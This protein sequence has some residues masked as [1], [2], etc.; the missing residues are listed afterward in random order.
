MHDNKFIQ[1]HTNTK[2]KDE[3][4][5]K[6]LWLKAETVKRCSQKWRHQMEDEH[7]VHNEHNVPNGNY[8]FIVKKDTNFSDVKTPKIV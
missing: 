8:F 3:E 6:K 4:K 7:N 5:L 2:T 1:V